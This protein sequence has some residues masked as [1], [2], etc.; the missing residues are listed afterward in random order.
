M[1]GTP[2]PTARATTSSPEAP[3]SMRSV[4]TRS[5]GASPSRRRNASVPEKAVVHRAPAFPR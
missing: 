2:R 1:A 4:I 3:G 5:K